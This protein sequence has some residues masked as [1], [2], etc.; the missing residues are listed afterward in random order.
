MK[1]AADIR[2]ELDALTAVLHELR[3]DQRGAQAAL[4]DAEVERRRLLLATL[5][6]RHGSA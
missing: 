6:T 3:D 2:A 1:S 4:L 5:L